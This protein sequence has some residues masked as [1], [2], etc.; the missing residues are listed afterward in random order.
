M[1]QAE[2]RDKEEMEKRLEIW[3]DD[4]SDETFYTDRCVS[5]S[6]QPTARLCMSPILP[7]SLLLTDPA[8]EPSAPGASPRKKLPTLNHGSTRKPRQRT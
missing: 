4:E 2:A 1:E 6:S 8:G 5:F 7:L 3:D